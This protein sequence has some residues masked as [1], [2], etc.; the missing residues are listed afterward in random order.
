MIVGLDFDNTIVSYDEVFHRVAVEGGHVPAELPVRKEAVRDFLRNAG[1]EDLWTEMQ[2]V[3]YGSRM[4]EARPFDGALETI[5]SIKAAGHR[6]VIVSHKTRYP[7][8]G[9][10][11]D[12]HA[13]A[14]R[15]LE[16]MGFFDP[17]GLAFQDTDVF[18]EPTKEDKLERIDRESCTHFV[19]DLPEILTHP[20]FPSGVARLLFVPGSASN[21]AD[22]T[23]ASKWS[24]ISIWLM[25]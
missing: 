11:H 19:D 21:H 2:G 7:F 13:A 24:E 16:V 1:A 22:L 9:E 6:V 20:L 18:F 4:G 12:L 8:L 5:T 25:R 17:Q 10:R 15:W 14:R 3:V 23:T